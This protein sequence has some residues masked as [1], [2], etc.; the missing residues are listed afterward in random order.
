VKNSDFDPFAKH[1]K[2]ETQPEP[3]VETQPVTKAVTNKQST[4]R[5]KPRTP[6]SATELL[7]WIQRHWG[8]P[9]I[10]LRDIQAY[11]PNA[12]RNRET[13]IAQVKTLVEFGWL[14]PTK[15]H[16]RDRIVWKTPPAGVRPLPN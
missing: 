10:S 11:G 12:I 8:K 9:I 2:V 15:S 16:R 1:R 6:V 7:H 5:P 3:I 4:D 14:T 13:A